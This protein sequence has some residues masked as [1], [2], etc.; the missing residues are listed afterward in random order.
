MILVRWQYL[1]AYQNDRVIYSRTL[2][3]IA[4]E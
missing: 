4:C 1:E 2:L 3:G